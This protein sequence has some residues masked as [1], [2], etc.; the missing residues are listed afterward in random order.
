MTSLSGQTK[1]KLE[2]I[3]DSHTRWEDVT[4]YEHGYEQLW[5]QTKENDADSSTPDNGPG[6]EV[7]ERDKFVYLTADST[8]EL[9]EF[10]EGEI[11]ILGGIV[12]HNRY[13]VSYFSNRA[14]YGQ[15]SKYC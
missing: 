7:Y 12:D 11:Y 8:C 5:P 3:G 15:A 9:E 14:F 1:A 13:K 2:S 6:S 10:K 4:W